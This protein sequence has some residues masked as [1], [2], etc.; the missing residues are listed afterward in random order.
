MDKKVLLIIISGFHPAGIERCEHPFVKE[1]KSNS[2][3]TMKGQTVYPS[4]SLPAC[5]SLCQSVPPQ[6]HG[7]MEE[8]YSIPSMPVQGLVERAFRSG[9]STAFN[10]RDI[11]RGGYLVNTICLN[12]EKND[13]CTRKLTKMAIDYIE[14]EKPDLF[15]IQ[16]TDMER[17]GKEL[18][19]VSTMYV[20]YT[21]TQMDCLQQLY[22]KY[23]D[24]YTFLIVSDHAGHKFKY[25]SDLPEDM[26]VPM[27]FIGEDFEKGKELE[28]CSILDIAPT[29]AKIMNFPP[30]KEWEGK[31]LI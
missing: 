16:Y 21:K 6:R 15:L 24:E 22:D 7:V 27:F 20:N 26:T 10:L 2:T 12:E 14:E 13:A 9:K 17:A 8:T 23:K 11:V 28:T 1:I 4:T 25:G 5:L 3:Y 19:W 18:G 30:V 29:V 31:S